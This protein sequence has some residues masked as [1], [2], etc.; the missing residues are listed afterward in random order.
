M[1]G[2]GLVMGWWWVVTGGDRLADGLG[3]GGN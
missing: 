1:G 3:M 2:D